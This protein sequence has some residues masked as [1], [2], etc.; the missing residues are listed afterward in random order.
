MYAVAFS[1]LVIAQLIVPSTMDFSM[2]PVEPQ[3]LKFARW[4]TIRAANGD[5]L[6]DGGWGVFAGK[7]SRADYMEAFVDMLV[8]ADCTFEQN[9]AVVVVKTLNGS[10]V[11]RVEV[12]TTGPGPLV[13]L[14]PKA[15]PVKAKKKD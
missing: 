2:F 10:P 6:D 15:R 5:V 8:E 7:Q 13:V 9:G 3:S 12:L 4:V 14:A 11:V 1:G